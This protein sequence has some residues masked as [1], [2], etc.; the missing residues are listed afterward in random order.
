MI[1]RFLD[2]IEMVRDAG[3]SFSL[4]LTPADYYIPYIDEIKRISIGRFDAP[5]HITVARK[6]TDPDL[7]I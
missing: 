6:E 4:E 3:C 5:C 7:P 1:D 2:N